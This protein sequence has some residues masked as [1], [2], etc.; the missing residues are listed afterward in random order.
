[1][2]RLAFALP[3]TQNSR[4]QGYL[5]SI[6]SSGT[7]RKTVGC[8]FNDKPAN[9]LFFLFFTHS[10]LFFPPFFKS[11]KSNNTWRRLANYLKRF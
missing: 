6:P 5:G 9:P 4:P 2:E 1:M 3:L 11:V 10:L 7:I 8:G